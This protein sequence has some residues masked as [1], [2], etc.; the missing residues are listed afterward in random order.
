M[1]S[2]QCVTCSQPVGHARFVT[3][4]SQARIVSCTLYDKVAVAIYQVNIDSVNYAVKVHLLKPYSL[5][6]SH[7]ELWKLQE[8]WS[9]QDLHPF[10]IP[11][12]VQFHVDCGFVMSLGK[13]IS[14]YIIDHFPTHKKT[15]GDSDAHM[16]PLQESG[17]VVLIGMLTFI[18]H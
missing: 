3:I 7:A 18:K 13:S 17:L 2:R 12:H 14:N 5:G 6:H 9:D 4:N 1:V 10:I 15:M 8:L 11:I 16:K